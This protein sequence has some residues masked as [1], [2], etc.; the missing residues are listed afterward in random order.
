MRHKLHV[1]GTDNFVFK[2]LEILYKVVCKCPWVNDCAG[3]NNLAMH[4][5]RALVNSERP[6]LTVGWDFGRYKIRK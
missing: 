6:I 1:Q 3:C 5:I 2:G 4:N